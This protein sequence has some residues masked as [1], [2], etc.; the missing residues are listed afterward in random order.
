MSP[1]AQIAMTVGAAFV[2]AAGR[3]IFLAVFRRRKSRIEEAD[4]LSGIAVEL[5]EP[6]RKELAATRLEHHE[7]MAKVKSETGKVY[8]EARGLARELKALRIAI[9]SPEAT[10]ELLRDMV[11]K[12]SVLDSPED[13]R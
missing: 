9:M 1:W 5:V 7:E 11:S 6:R 8:R 13:E 10:L 4:V 3:E 12:P 2:A